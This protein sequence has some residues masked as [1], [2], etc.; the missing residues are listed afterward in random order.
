LLDDDNPRENLR[1]YI[2]SES[3]LYHIDRALEKNKDYLKLSQYGYLRELKAVLLL[4]IIFL[5][6][7]QD[8]REE[9]PKLYSSFSKETIL[10]VLENLFSKLKSGI[11]FS[12][13]SDM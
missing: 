10:Y 4:I 8:L 7:K 2:D 5:L 11:D 6:N 13:K 9:I 1:H 12:S 3:D